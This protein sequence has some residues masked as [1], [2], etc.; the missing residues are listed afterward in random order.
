M[1]TSPLGAFPVAM[2]AGY[3]VSCIFEIGIVV[4]LESATTVLWCV[5][6]C[7]GSS[8]RDFG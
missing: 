6:W 4:Y 1:Q 8:W 2:A 7:V 5:L 3:L